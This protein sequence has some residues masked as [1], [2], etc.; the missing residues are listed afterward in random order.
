[1]YRHSRQLNRYMHPI[2]SREQGLGLVKIQYITFE[3]KKYWEPWFPGL[4]LKRVCI[5]IRLTV[6]FSIHPCNY[7]SLQIDVK[8]VIRLLRNPQVHCRVYKRTVADLIPIF[9]NP[10]PHNCWSSNLNVSSQL[11]L[12]VTCDLFPS[13]LSA[14]LLFIAVRFRARYTPRPTCVR[15][16]KL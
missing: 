15:L 2:D 11:N 1:M 7:I 14:N 6:A 4:T 9:I 10:H 12:A 3:E 8:A 5:W 13:R 16:H